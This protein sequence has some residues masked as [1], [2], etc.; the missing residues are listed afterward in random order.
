METIFAILTVIV[1][2][3]LALVGLVALTICVFLWMVS[4]RTRQD[5]KIFQERFDGWQQDAQIGSPRKPGFRGFRFTRSPAG[6]SRCPDTAFQQNG[7]S[8]PSRSAPA[9]PLA[10][11]GFRPDYSLHFLFPAY[12]LSNHL[13]ALQ[14]SSPLLVLN[15]RKIRC[16][17]SR[18]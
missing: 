18:A 7:L 17:L 15:T 9:A 2:I 6:R 13:F 11:S 3:L 1:Y 10:P 8:A 14:G 12:H 5:S 4:T 16:H